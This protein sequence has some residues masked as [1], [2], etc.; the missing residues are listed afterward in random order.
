MVKKRTK[1][2][3]KTKD[4]I[5]AAFSL[6]FILAM[7]FLISYIAKSDLVNLKFFSENML[8]AV[9]I[10]I[11]FLALEVVV[12][13][14][15][16]YPLIP[17]ASNLFGW[18]AAGIYSLIGWTIGSFIAFFIAQKYGKPI[19][20]KIVSLKNIEKYEKR[21][22]QKNVFLSVVLL[23]IFLP[24][25]IVSYALGLFTKMKKTTYTLATLIGY[26]PLAFVI[27]YLGVI[28]L[29]YQVIGFI[30]G[31]LILLIGGWLIIKKLDNYGRLS[32]LS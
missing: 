14:I 30:I 23:R 20:S 25:D 4:K 17:I 26:A 7:F 22:P 28:P 29:Y 27:S 24:I 8:L 31:G 1:K 32:I 12:L 19:L 15:N 9:F 2:N 3:E 21:M 6:L 5:K 11:L 10:Y 13:P 18:I 16:S